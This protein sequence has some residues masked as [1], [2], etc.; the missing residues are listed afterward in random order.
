VISAPSRVLAGLCS[1]LVA[2]VAGACASSTNSAS[3]S[4]SSCVSATA[5]PDA[6]APSYAGEVAAIIKDTCVTCHGPT[7]TAGFDMS[8]YA[9]ASAEAGAMLSQVTVCQMPPL[10]APAMTDAER[11][12]LTA[13]LRCGA[14]DN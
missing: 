3:S 9:K 14:P 11:T 13:W 5:C 8:T 4:G 2:L 12:A 10:D 1:A 7:G 6:G